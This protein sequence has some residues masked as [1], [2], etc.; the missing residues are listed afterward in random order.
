SSKYEGLPEITIGVTRCSS[1]VAE[2][3]Q[4]RSPQYK[5][6]HALDNFEVPIDEYDVAGDLVLA[7]SNQ[8]VVGGARINYLH[9]SGG[10]PMHAAGLLPEADLLSSLPGGA[11]LAEVSRYAFLPEFRQFELMQRHFQFG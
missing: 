6:V 10:L 5:D 1:M 8:R 11:R 7:V 4:L 9:R 3:L 2:Y